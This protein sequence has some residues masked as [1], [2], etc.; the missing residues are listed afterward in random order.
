[1]RFADTETGELR[2]VRALLRDAQR[3]RVA[4]STSFGALTTFVGLLNCRR[5][6]V[7]TVKATT[8]RPRRREPADAEPH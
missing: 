4:A 5:V 8:A 3:S 1:M 2:R 6:V 7:P